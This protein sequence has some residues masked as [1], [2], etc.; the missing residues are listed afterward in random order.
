VNDYNRSRFGDPCRICGFD[1]STDSDTCRL[2]IRDASVRFSALTSE[3]TG[4][5]H[6]D[7][8]DW[9]AR[10]YVVHVGDGM[11]IWAERVAA[12][13]LGAVEPIVTYDESVLGDVRGYQ[14]L[15]LQGGLWSLQ[16]A[17]GDWQDAEA[18]ADGTDLVLDHPEQGTIGLS[19]VR[20]IVAH[21]VEHHAFDLSLILNH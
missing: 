11:R 4:S 19:E 15:A 6:H 1:W 21:D 3:R 20:C 7:D 17:S 10:A 16:R 14:G 18:L 5:E 8:L 2:I 12:A 9:N 13:A